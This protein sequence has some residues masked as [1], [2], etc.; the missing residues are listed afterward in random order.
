VLTVV[1]GVIERDGWILIAQRKPGD[2]LEHQWEFPGGKVEPGETP[3]EALV[4]ELREE[5]GVETEVGPYIGV[6]VFAYAHITIELLA[7]WVRYHSG[8]FALHDHQAIRWVSIPELDKY[9]FAPA[10]IPLVQLV[11]EQGL[12]RPD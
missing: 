12:P 7:Y 5:F 11:Q 3:P 9:P 2:R 6:S 8:T 4:R 1:A 10:D